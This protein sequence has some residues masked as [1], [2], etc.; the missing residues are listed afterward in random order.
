MAVDLTEGQLVEISERLKNC[1]SKERPKTSEELQKFIDKSTGVVKEAVETAIDEDKHLTQRMLEAAGVIIRS[2]I[3]EI[4]THE[5]RLRLQGLWHHSE[6]VVKYED[7]K[8]S[9]LG[10]KFIQWFV[11]FAHTFRLKNV[12]FCHLT[13]PA[14]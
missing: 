2:P 12:C 13:F 7:T 14:V 5:R 11:L 4:T 1:P 6:D 8:N 10:S 3:Q 9:Y